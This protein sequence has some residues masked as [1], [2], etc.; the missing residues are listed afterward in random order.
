[1]LLCKYLLNNYSVFSQF[2]LHLLDI[3]YCDVVSYFSDIAIL[4][5]TIL[6]LIVTTAQDLWIRCI[7]GLISY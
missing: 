4:V 7:H 6:K 2:L 3:W 1:M 5:I